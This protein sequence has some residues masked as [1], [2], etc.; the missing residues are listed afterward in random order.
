SVLS[1]YF[2]INPAPSEPALLSLHDALPI[3]DRRV[4]PQTRPDDAGDASARG[5]PPR[6]EARK[7]HDQPPRRAGD[8][9]ICGLQ[10]A[11]DHPVLRSEEHTSELQSL[12]NLVCRLLLEKTKALT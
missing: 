7:Y 9:D 11:V 2:S 4:R 5:D 3:P 1:P 12:T 6:P 8:H 10:V